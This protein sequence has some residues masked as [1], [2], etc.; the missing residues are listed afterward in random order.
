MEVK[1]GQFLTLDGGQLTASKFDTEHGDSLYRWSSRRSG[2]LAMANVSAA[3]ALRDS[4]F[5]RG[6]SQWYWNPYFS[7]FTFIPGMGSMIYSPFGYG[8]YSP[9]YVYIVYRPRPQM[10][11]SVASGGMGGG[12]VY[13]PNLGYSTASSRSYGG[14]TG[15]A[16]TAPAAAASAPAPIPRG[17]ESAAPRSAAGGG[18]G[19]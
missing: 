16:A 5:D 7:M 8:Y 2:Y 4:G 11:S 14:Y 6:A 13:N 18:R 9:R 19:Q 17:A 1:K 12:P 3:R 15:A 10:P